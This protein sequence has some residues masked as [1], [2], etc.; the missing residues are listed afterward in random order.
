MPVDAAGGR[1]PQDPTAVVIEPGRAAARVILG[2]VDAALRSDLPAIAVYVELAAD[3]PRR[4][5]LT[6][7]LEADPRVA[8]GA[9]EPADAPTGPIVVRM[10]AR[11]RPQPRTI[12]ALVQMVASGALGSAQVVVPGRVAALGRLGGAG[13]LRVEGAGSGTRRVRPGEVGLRSTTSPGEPGPP[14]KG[15]L[16]HE[17]AEHLRHR[18]RSATMRARMDRNTQRLYRERLQSRHDRTRRRLAEQRLATTSGGEWVRWRLRNV[19]RRL[20]G[21][22][23]VAGSGLSSV[24]VFSRRARRFAGERWRSRGAGTP[25]PNP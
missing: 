5:S 22:P 7:L 3:D 23:A 24:R 13:T 12:P 11:A 19:G 18:A 6:P 1:N 25:K 10:P 9:G 20:A 16:E 15:G 4:R 8:I 17:R 14:P 21:L 2:A